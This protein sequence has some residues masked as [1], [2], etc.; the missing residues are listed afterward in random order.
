[1]KFYIATSSLNI[2]NILSTECV[3]PLSFYQA[4]NYGYSTFYGLELIPYKNIL[5]LFSKIPH[6]EISDGDHD[7]R[8]AIL[9][10]DIKDETNPLDFIGEYE[11]IKM[12]S[13]DTIIRLSP[14]NTRILFFNPKDL[15]LSR[16]S[17]S[18]SLTNKIGN[19]FIFDLCKADFDLARISDFNFHID[20]I[21]KDYEQKVLLDN[22]L[23]V[24]KGFV[25]GYYLGV[26][27]SV[28]SDNAILLRIQKRIYDI[29]ATIKNSGGYGNQ[30]FY[31]ELEQLDKEY[32]QNDP[33]TRKCKKLWK[34]T[35]EGL[36]I[37][38]DALDKLL[39][40]YDE[41]NVVK[42]TF[43]KKNKL[44]SLVSLR[45]YG[46]NLEAYRDNLKNHTSAIIREDRQKQ[47][48]IFDV[49]STF[50]IDPSYET[51]ML[52]GEDSESMVFNKF[53]DAILWHGIAPSPDTLRTD[54]FNIATQITIITKNIWESLN[55]E[56]QDSS[57]Q[58]FMNELR[59]NIKSFTPFDVNK[60]NDIVLKSIAA[61]VLKGED[62]D[63]IVQYCEDNTYANYRYA[64][65]LW[66]ATQG[67][68]KISKP[69]IASIVNLSS[70]AET[71][72]VI[73]TLLYNTEQEGDWPLIQQPFDIISH[74][75]DTAVVNPNLRQ[76]VQT[77]INALTPDQKRANESR[78]ESALQLEAA[79][80]NFE[81]YLYIL[82][83]LISSRTNLYKEMKRVLSLPESQSQEL[84]YVVKS[85]LKGFSKKSEKE[86]RDKALA[87]LALE[88]KVGDPV[89]F[90]YMLDDLN[91]S[92][93]IRDKFFAHF[94]IQA[95][96]SGI[97]SSIRKIGSFFEDFFSGQDTN[98]H[99]E[100]E[101]KET[102]LGK[103]LKPINKTSNSFVYDENVCNYILSRQYLPFE[104]R[105]LLS[106][107]VVQFQKGYAPGGKYF[108]DQTNNPTDN[109]ST[110]S[111]FENW[112]FYKGAYGSIVDKN[113]TNMNYFRQLKEDLLRRYES[114]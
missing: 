74:N 56:W 95:E 36:A 18:D 67:Y 41:K 75:V 2:D 65:A 45:Q 80:G 52:A 76:D 47:L 53:I 55:W 7:N 77:V 113:E 11:G 20:D 73:C 29:V 81:A 22:R 10:I 25:F 103:S 30:T 57:A 94:N 114:R 17:C 112:C 31:N 68:V 71:Y 38:M 37:P 49:K 108:K 13:T 107:K 66:G 61:F 79:Q 14:F 110:I 19:R 15:N 97:M 83:N 8:P 6:F 9:E 99:T 89:S 92:K 54:R 98:N 70:F 42:N 90:C 87:A 24:V 3:A 88:N 23:N 58:F 32:R 21:C 60:Q 84:S 39:E 51:C 48:S 96:E 26:S 64:L 104:F 5:I 85:V 46:Y 91:V 35:L 33:S 44:Q 100:Q 105:D 40:D 1:M 16:L 82:N 102:S 69:I 27:K 109:V 78:I 63:S 28:S 93:D 62:Y 4:R 101:S 43:I 72:R 86:Y 106:K 50:D 59:Q 12:Y 111:H 34:E